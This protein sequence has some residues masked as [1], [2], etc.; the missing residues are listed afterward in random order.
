MF[1][2]VK[3]NAVPQC[4]RLAIFNDVENDNNEELIRANA[5]S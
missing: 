5:K 1:V 2:N 4:G 3:G